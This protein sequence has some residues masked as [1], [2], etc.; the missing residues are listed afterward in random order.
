VGEKAS[1]EE[2]DRL[3]SVDQA[4]RGEARRR[5]KEKGSLARLLDVERV[6]LVDDL[7][8]ALA[9]IA[10]VVYRSLEV[11]TRGLL[12]DDIAERSDAFSTDAPASGD[13]IEVEV[14]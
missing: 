13:E 10:V 11:R 6:E 14:E 2:R 9:L 12:Q 3:G 4:G 5:R 1:V 7:A 8:E